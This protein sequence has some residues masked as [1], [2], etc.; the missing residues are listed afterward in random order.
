ME[1]HCL[2]EHV[3]L[4]LSSPPK[5]R[6]AD[7]LGLVKGQSAVRIPR[8]L[9]QERRRTRVHF[10]A[11]GYGVSTVGWEE[12]QGRQDLREQE[13]LAQRQGALDFA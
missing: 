11:A 13:D 3:H 5:Y 1:G 7:T 10:G 9:W 4:G 2:P 12:A 6:V 8:E